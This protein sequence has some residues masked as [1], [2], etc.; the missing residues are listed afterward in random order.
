MSGWDVAGSQAVPAIF[1]LS[2]ESGKIGPRGWKITGTATAEI[3]DKNVVF[4]LQGNTRGNHISLS[5]H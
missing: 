2:G 4:D 3:G 1:G 5:N